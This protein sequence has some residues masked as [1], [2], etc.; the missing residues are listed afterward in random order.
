MRLPARNASLA[1]RAGFI[2]RV[3]PGAKGAPRNDKKAKSAASPRV[4]G[5]SQ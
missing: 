3:K 5:S 1:R 4:R 2:P